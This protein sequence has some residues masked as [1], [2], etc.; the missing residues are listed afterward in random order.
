MQRSYREPK[1]RHRVFGILYLSA[2]SARELRR[3]LV[4]KLGVPDHA[5]KPNLHLTVYESRRRLEGLEPFSKHVRIEVQS[6]D[7]RFMAVAPGG[8]NPRPELDPASRPLALRIRRA[9]AAYSEIQQCRSQFLAL[10]TPEVL[11]G[12][13]PSGP[14][15]SAFGSHHYQ[16]HITVCSRDHG[17]TGDLRPYGE[18]LRTSLRSVRFNRLVCRVHDNSGII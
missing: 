8:E 13:S 9:S 16:P 15:R 11:S 2:E 6:N 18:I 3:V 14:R 7:L 12:R 4:G 10:E 5:V 17:L 1:H